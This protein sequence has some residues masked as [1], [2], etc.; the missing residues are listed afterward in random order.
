VSDV[1]AVST[2]GPQPARPGWTPTPLGELCEFIRGVTFDKG[3][4]SPDPRDRC[5]PILRAG[6]ISEGLDLKNDLVW[7]PAERV[8]TQQYLRV[9]DIAICMSSGSP[10]V[11]GKSAALQQPFAGSVGAFCGIIRLRDARWSEYIALWLRSPVFMD[12]RDG[13]ARGANI[14]NLRFSQFESLAVLAPPDHERDAFVNHL[15]SQL[16]AAARMRAA[17]ESQIRVADSLTAALLRSAFSGGQ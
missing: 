3:E 16:D 15:R 7:V 6:N 4:A 2:P 17:A 13:Q 9:G 10:A 8:S 1:A 12:W 5:L 11:V 14:Q